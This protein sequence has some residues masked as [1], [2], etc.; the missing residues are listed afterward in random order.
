MCLADM[1]IC[2]LV[3]APPMLLG[4]LVRSNLYVIF[5][6]IVCSFQQIRRNRIDF[7]EE[8]AD[9]EAKIA[10]MKKYVEVEIIDYFLSRYEQLNIF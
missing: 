9:Y 7:E 1:K 6:N 8:K 2:V 3:L 10:E 4:S 5:K